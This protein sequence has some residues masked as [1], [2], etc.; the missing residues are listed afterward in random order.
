MDVKN[1]ISDLLTEYN[2]SIY[3]LARESDLSES[4]LRSVFSRDNDPSLATLESI[5]KGFNI[6]L[7]QFFKA[8]DVG[9]GDEEHKLLV[10]Y[11]SLLP[12]HRKIVKDMIDALK[13]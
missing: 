8:E 1:R 11:N 9:A 7:P 13:K 5:C 4:T 6:T 10:A 12:E 2:W 3:R